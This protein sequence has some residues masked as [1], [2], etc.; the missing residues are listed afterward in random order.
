MDTLINLSIIDIIYRIFNQ[1]ITLLNSYRDV[2]LFGS[3]LDADKTP[4]DID[5]LLVYSTYSKKMVRELDI[6]RLVFEE[7]SGLPVDLTVLSVDE[8]KDTEFLKKLNSM[9][10]KLK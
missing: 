5:M 4:N 2:Y 8:E 3:I 1:Q 9:Y 6:I 10:V 7:L